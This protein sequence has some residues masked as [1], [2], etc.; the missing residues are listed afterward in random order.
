MLAGCFGRGCDPSFFDWGGHPGEG[1]MIDPDTWES[2]PLDGT[3]LPLP[4]QGHLRALYAGPVPRSPRTPEWV[5]VYISPSDHPIT[6]DPPASFTPSGGNL[7]KLFYFPA[8]VVET[9]AGKPRPDV[10]EVWNDSCSD[11]YARIIVHASESTRPAAEDGGI[12]ESVDSGDAGRA[13]DASSE[14][15]H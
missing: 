14:G 5:Q 8:R 13:S 9:D 4:H 1:Q 3:W 7:S 11:Y 2:N 10:L 15:G 6:N 12:D